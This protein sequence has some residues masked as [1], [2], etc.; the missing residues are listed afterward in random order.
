[1]PISFK[2]P[3]TIR[4]FHQIYSCSFNSAH[5]TYMVCTSH[6]RIVTNNTQSEFLLKQSFLPNFL[7]SR[8]RAAPEK[9]MLSVCVCVCVCACV[10]ALLHEHVWPRVSQLFNHLTNHHEMWY[11]IHQAKE[12][13]SRDFYYVQPAITDFTAEKGKD[14]NGRVTVAMGSMNVK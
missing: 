1:M 10:C 5:A 3:L 13:H 11:A 2:R 7:S 8:E 14:G 4:V 12:S 9:A 6:P